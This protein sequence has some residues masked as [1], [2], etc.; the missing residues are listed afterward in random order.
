M[1]HRYYTQDI[2]NGTA[3][4]TGAD[5]MHLTKVLRAKVGQPLVLCDGANTDYDAV[6]TAI[7]PQQ[8]TLQ[9]TASHPSAAEPTVWAEV[10]I[11]YSKGERMEYAIQ[12]SVE[13][14][15]SYIQPFFSEYCVVK[16]KN[17]EA[18][19]AR[20]ARIAV[21]AAKQSGR[22]ILPQVGIACSYTEMLAK[23]T[24]CS[25]AFFLYE[26]G[27][28]ALPQA[29]PAK[30]R[31]AVITGAEGGFSVQEVQQAVQQGCVTIG[32]GPRILR[33]ETAP[34]AALAVIMA[35]SGNLQG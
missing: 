24:V 8:V 26:K 22:G 33:C 34:V 32:L 30:G 7:S 35:V 4:I 25:P 16:P 20:F 19:Q 10:Y 17:E 1:A 3:N 21:E 5:A 9:I 23:A 15:A 2:Y 27:G 12:K 13:L 31:V 28:V 11:G 6:I 29:V 18:K 14:G